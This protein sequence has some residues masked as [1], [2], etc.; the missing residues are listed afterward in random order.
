MRARWH[1]DA[2]GVR[3][4]VRGARRR[5]QA[6]QRYRFLV[7]AAIAAVTA[8][9]AL[10]IKATFDWAGELD[11]IQDVMGVTSKEAAALNFVLRKSGT[12]TEKL[13]K[14]MVVLEKGLFKADGTLDTVGQ[15][16]AEFGINA[17]DV[18]GQ[19]K[20]QAKLIDEIGQKYNSLG[21][22]T[23]RVNF[24][25]E[26]FGRSGA[27]LIDVFDTLAAEGGIEKTADKVE[28]LGLAIDPDK[29]EKFQRNLNEIKLAGLG[30]AVTIVDTLMPSL[31]GFNKWWETDGL[32]AFQ[33]MVK[34]LQTNLPTAIDKTK[35]ASDGVADSWRRNVTPVSNEL[36]RLWE[37]LSSIAT[38][39]DPQVNGLASKFTILGATQRVAVGCATVV[40]GALEGLRGTL[41]TINSIL[42]RAIGLWDRFRSS[43][44]AGAS[45]AASVRV[46][47]TTST[48][49]TGTVSK[50]IKSGRA[51]GGT[52]V[53]GGAYRFNERGGKQEVLIPNRVGT[54]ANSIDVNVRFSDAELD[55]IGRSMARSLVPA[56]QRVV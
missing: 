26:L 38:R 35:R 15:K 36:I 25:T 47:S 20:D 19:M 5:N 29:Y 55:R 7:S 33:G 54:V 52:V 45:A 40:N 1:P 22:Q 16:M 12:E 42:E 11:S 28:K 13:T 41:A 31:E 34:W 37:N 53:P 56:L 24:L 17:L 3:D 43:A 48:G 44:L 10:A 14:G 9:A 49:S 21:T 4:A 50:P 46:P 8:A 32:S 39:L 51:V 6:R 27:D 2:G 18:N 30:L 23:E